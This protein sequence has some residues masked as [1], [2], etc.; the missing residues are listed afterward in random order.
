[1]QLQRARRRIEA[2]GQTP[3]GLRAVTASLVALEPAMASLPRVEGKAPVMAVEFKEAVTALSRI[4]T[5]DAAAQPGRA[6]PPLLI[7]LDAL[8]DAIVPPICYALAASPIDA[9]ETVSEAW[10]LHS[11]TKLKDGGPNQ[12]WRRIA[13]QLPASEVRSQGG[14]AVVGA[15]VALDVAFAQSKLVRLPSPDFPAPEWLSELDAKYLIQAL[16]LGDGEPDQTALHSAIDALAAGRKRVTAWTMTP[17]TAG[18][19]TA[20]LQDRARRSVADQRHHLGSYPPVAR[21]IRC[22]HPHGAFSFGRRTGASTVIDGSG[23]GARRVSLPRLQRAT[24]SR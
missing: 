5:S 8:T 9:P 7:A 24:P 16:V 2:G 15:L 12:P 17:P 22:A 11:F 20:A 10:T 19:L 18:D 14:T 13:W 23:D 4:S 21:R 1:M 6:L 3:D